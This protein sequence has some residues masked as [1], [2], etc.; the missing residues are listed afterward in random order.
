MRN[1]GRGHERRPEYP[2][3]RCRSRGSGEMEPGI[4]PQRQVHSAVREAPA[5]DVRILPP[6]YT[7]EQGACRLG[8]AGVLVIGAGK[9][10]RRVVRDDAGKLASHEIGLGLDVETGEHERNL[11]AVATE[12]VDPHLERVW[13]RFTADAADP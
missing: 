13:R 6:H 12:R 4:A 2:V 8:R 3:W 9:R 5:D 1:S 11:V 10:P 7:V